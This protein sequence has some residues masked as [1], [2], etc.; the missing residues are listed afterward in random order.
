MFKLAES[1]GS[2]R[3]LYCGREG[4]FLGPSPLIECHQGIYRLR[5]RDE[6]AVLL[7]AAYEPVPDLA[8]CLAK[9]AEVLAAFEER[10]ITRAMIAA[11]HLRL[12]E[13]LE[14]R[15]ARLVGAEALLKYNINPDQPRDWHGRWT[16]EG[17]ASSTREASAADHP[18]L[19]PAQELLPFGARPPL[20]F[21]EPPKTFRPFKEPIPG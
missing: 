21:D 7:A 8:R 2:T 3:G 1:R 12:G 5:P 14:E 17:S 4:L 6:V 18:A 16:T 15:M 9:L 20:F 11:L 13:I 10:D 19:V